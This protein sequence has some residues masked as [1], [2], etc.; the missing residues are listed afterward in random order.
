[1]LKSNGPEPA[2]N[3]SPLTSILTQTE[4]GLVAGGSADCPQL[5]PP[6]STDAYAASGH[7]LIG[8]SPRLRLGP[9]MVPT[10]LA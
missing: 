7:T 8:Q 2:A 10:I 3:Q 6:S 1:M 9:Q 5:N 4:M